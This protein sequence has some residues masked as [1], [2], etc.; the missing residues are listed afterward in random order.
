V[1]LIVVTNLPPLPSALAIA[2]V[3][4]LFVTNSGRMI[5]AMA[6]VTSS[7]PPQSRG[8]F[9]S[10]NSSVQ[11]IASGLGTLLASAIIVKHDDGRLEHFGTVGLIACGITLLS[12]W[13]AGRL[14]P[15]VAG[16]PVSVETEL[17]GITAAEHG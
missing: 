4:G 8:G 5:P 1:M 2:V 3:A 10:A 17:A 9:M 14:R 15:Y 7:V 11:H 12:L 16:K 6:M 13:L